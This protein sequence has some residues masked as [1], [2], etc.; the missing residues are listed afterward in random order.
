MKY[1]NFRDGKVY[2]EDDRWV[3]IRGNH[4]LIKEKA[5]YLN[6]APNEQEV[7]IVNNSLHPNEFM[8][9]GGKN[10]NVLVVRGNPMTHKEAD[11]GKVNPT[12]SNTNCTNS[13]VA[14][15]LRLRGFDV[16]AGTE[17]NWQHSDLSKNGPKGAW[18]TETGK[19]PQEKHF[20]GDRSAIVNAIDNNIKPGER[21]FLWFSWNGGGGHITT[22]T[23]D[24]W[25]RLLLYDPQKNKED[26]GTRGLEDLINAADPTRK[27]CGV[28]GVGLMRVDNLIPRK[29][30]MSGLLI[31]NKRG[32][33][34]GS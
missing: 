7:Y 29:S 21:H 11:S 24:K 30:Y 33:Q 19:T 22:I 10:K 12:N 18:M 14:Y 5:D 25:G 17:Y 1:A 8:V 28:Q 27:P 26:I 31:A 6:G 16:V 32:A 2:I 9:K 13:C 20:T 4:V 3:T 34:N 23:K 15:E